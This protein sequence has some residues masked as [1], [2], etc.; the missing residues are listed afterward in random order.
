MAT[1]SVKIEQLEPFFFL[2]FLPYVSSIITPT[3]TVHHY[4]YDYTV[5]LFIG[6]ILRLVLPP[7]PPLTPPFFNGRQPKRQAPLSAHT[8][9]TV[10]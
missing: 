8:T 7:P 1:I 5:L 9:G 3:H 10:Y 6:S 2:I 4:Y